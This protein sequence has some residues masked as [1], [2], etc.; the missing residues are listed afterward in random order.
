MS[1]DIVDLVSGY[2][3]LKRSGRNFKGLC[4]FHEEK[5]PSFIVSPDRQTYKCFGCGEGGNAFL[6]LQALERLTFPEAVRELAERAGIRIETETEAPREAKRREEALAALRFASEHFQR[7]LRSP[8]GRRALEY[9][10]GRGMTDDTIDAFAL[11]FAPDSWD[12]L[13]RAARAEGI[14]ADALEHAGLVLP[15][16]DGSHYD[17]FRNRVVF[18]IRDPQG[19][20]VGFGA[21]ALGD[22]PP[23][24]LNSPDSDLFR[25]GSILYGLREA[26]DALRDATEIAVGEGYTDVILAHQAGIPNVVATLGTALTPAHARLLRRFVERVVLVFDADDAGAKA[27]ER[28]VETLLEADLDVAVARLPAGVD[29]CDLI[30][31]EGEEAMRRTLDSARDFFE[32]RLERELASMGDASLHDRARAGDRLLAVVRRVQSPLKRGLLIRRLA[33]ALDIPEE[34]LLVAVRDASRQG[35][36]SFGTREANAPRPGPGAG[37]SPSRVPRGGPAPW[38]GPGSQERAIGVG[39]A[40]PGTPARREAPEWTGGG[41][42]PA[43]LEAAGTPRP[44]AVPRGALVQAES[45]LLEV[46]LHRPEMLAASEDRLGGPPAWTLPRHRELAELVRARLGDERPVDPEELLA[47]TTDP[48]VARLLTRFLARGRDEEELERLAEGALRFFER[49]RVKTSLRELA[50]E[51]RDALARG[52]AE[53]IDRVLKA[54]FETIRGAD[55]GDVARNE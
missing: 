36:R 8:G 34:P 18:T 43:G 51:R 46:W 42:A 33:E 54:T 53:G 13:V 7:Q 49:S 55:S 52:D 47:E 14:G 17:R 6:F 26:K 30:V 11:G 28:G 25:K 5:T 35:P 40:S 4:P 24:Y 44:D 22:E 19:R 31:A 41:E 45:D 23:K 1:T 38:G 21:R 32:F 37:A 3:R 27:S 10:R 2:V 20:V 29:P 15:R 9:L 12:S 39:G 48:D 50:R 16:R